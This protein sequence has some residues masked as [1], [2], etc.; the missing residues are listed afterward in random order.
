MLLGIDLGTSNT[1]AATLGRDGS[2]ILIPDSSDRD[3]VYTP[4]AVVIDGNLAFAG[5]MAE[6][7]QILKPDKKIVRY[8]KRNFGTGNPVYIDQKGNN[9]FSETVAAIMLKKIKFDAELYA[10]DSAGQ[11]VITVP[12]HYNDAQRRSV[13][14]A[15]RLAG[16]NLAALVEEPIAAA[17]SYFNHFS[18]DDEII[19]V[20]DFGGG[21]FDLTL[22]TR[23]AGQV[24]VLAKDGL[25]NLGGKEF[26]EIIIRKIIQDYASC[27]GNGNSE[28]L[29]NDRMQ[30]M[31]EKIKHAICRS[32]ED[33]TKWLILERM[34]FEFNFSLEQFSILSKD[35][36]AKTRQIT[37]RC[38]RSIGLSIKDIHK[39]LL[40]GGT[41]QIPFIQKYWQQ[42]TVS[43][44]IEVIV[45]EP[46]ASIA[47][48]AATY[49]G[50]LTGHFHAAQPVAMQ[51]VS[52]H[53]IAIKNINNREKEDVLIQK[54]L[55]LPVSAKRLF[56]LESGEVKELAL[57]QFWDAGESEFT[58]GIIKLGPYVHQKLVELHVENRTNGTIGLKLKDSHS[59]KDIK[60]D[61]IREKS[62]HAYSFEEQKKLLEGVI[63]NNTY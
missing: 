61:F 56:K 57:I 22:V 36:V 28:E 58:S 6:L 31:A 50:L 26:D 60:L 35:I 3:I 25:S 7:Y 29:V 59:G 43:T 37:D 27:T 51:S 39:I 34:A 14:E 41:S 46:L 1:L 13:I 40:V 2:P 38:L 11:A 33:Y 63:V 10:A 5:A 32:G 62:A 47:L 16:L 9:W 8:Y 19:M 30:Q 55:P 15:S 24:Y 54:N 52:S 49:A 12:A 42:E 23:S 18:A 4:S 48:G 17:L 20:Y 45:Y 53:N 44:N 21:T